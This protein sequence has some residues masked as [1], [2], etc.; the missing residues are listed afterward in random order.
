[1]CGVAAMDSRIAFFLHSLFCFGIGS[2]NKS[3]IRP[4]WQMRGPAP[5]AVAGFTLVELLVVIAII[6]ILVGLLLPAVQSAREAARRMQCTNNLKQFGLA[7]HNYASAM[8]RFPSARS[9]TNMSAHASLLPYF[10]QSNVNNLVDWNVAWNHANN[11]AARAAEIPIFN[12]PSDPNINIPVG[13]AGTTY[14]VNQGSGIL[15]AQPS[16]TP[17][18][19][20]FGLPAPNGVIVPAR[21]LRFADILDGTSQTAAFSEHGKGDFS[22]AIAS[23]TDT[24]WPQTFPATPDEAYAQCEAINPKDLQYQRVSDVGA[25]WLQGYH[26]TTIYFHVAP[27]NRRSC[28]FPPGRISTTAKS[29][30]SGGVNV[31]MADGSVGFKAQTIDLQV[32]RA[33]GSRDG[34]EAISGET[35]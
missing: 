2:M 7:L 4:G 16:T 12:C 34:A 26:S 5:V 23:F 25:P 1:M 11:A 15:N 9:S 14:R 3:S 17:G 30:H 19:P 22:N 32:W 27:P 6:G 20:N 10:E 24:F 21:Y 28:M 18:D 35:P 33:L 8:N 13:W 29:F 31:C